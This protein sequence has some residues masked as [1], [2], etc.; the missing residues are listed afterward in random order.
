[1]S[2]LFKGITGIMLVE[3]LPDRF[4][5]IADSSLNNTAPDG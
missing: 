5:S 3:I 2:N 4:S 1:M